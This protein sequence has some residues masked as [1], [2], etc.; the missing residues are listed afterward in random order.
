MYL[1]EWRLNGLAISCSKM[2]SEMQS[3]VLRFCSSNG[4][5][6]LAPNIP[7][8]FFQ[9][10]P[11]LGTTFK[12]PEEVAKVTEG[13]NVLSGIMSLPFEMNKR[14]NACSDRGAFILTAP[15]SS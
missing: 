13:T 3:C 8:Q 9:T 4:Q 14:T 6:S 10:L 1:V 2:S 15:H 7:D 11:F 5:E 12:K